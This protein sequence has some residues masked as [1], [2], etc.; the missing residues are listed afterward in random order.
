MVSIELRVHQV[1]LLYEFLIYSL[2]LLVYSIS[3]DNPINMQN[4]YEFYVIWQLATIILPAGE[5]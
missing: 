1:Y 2:E 5:L 3:S 4:K